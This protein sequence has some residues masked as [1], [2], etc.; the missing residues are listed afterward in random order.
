VLLT[1][2]AKRKKHIS[3][4]LFVSDYFARKIVVYLSCFGI[5]VSPN[6]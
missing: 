3:V 2:V 1:G 6:M 5:A 4:L